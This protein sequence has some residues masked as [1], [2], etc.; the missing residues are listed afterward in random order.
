MFPISKSDV[1]IYSLLG[2]HSP[3]DNRCLVGVNSPIYALDWL[4]SL[5]RI[6]ARASWHRTLCVLLP[7]L[8][9]HRPWRK[10]SEVMNWSISLTSASLT[11]V[12]SSTWQISSP[13]LG[14]ITGN[15]FP[16]A[17]LCHSL[18]MKICVYLISTGEA[19]ESVD[20][21]W[22]WKRM[23]VV[24]SLQMKREESGIFVICIDKHFVLEWNTPTHRRL[25][26]CTRAFSLLSFLLDATKG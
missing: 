25:K 4:V 2:G 12:P 1:S 20:D 10:K 15:V 5:D 26:T 8:Y 21:I 13:V 11:F 24:P 3:K 18:L 16:F 7:P 23:S 6:F 19:F 14:L 9:R 17:A 22:K